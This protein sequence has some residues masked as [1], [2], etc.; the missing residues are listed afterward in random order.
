MVFRPRGQ[1]V[2]PEDAAAARMTVLCLGDSNFF[3]YP[4]DDHDAFPF[5]LQEALQEGLGKAP[6]CVINAGL[7]GYSSTQGRIWYEAEFS[8]LPYKWLLVSFL[9][10]DAWEQPRTD[11]ELLSH[12]PTR[13]Q[14]LVQD[15]ISRSRLLQAVQAMMPR[16]VSPEDYVS[17]VELSD[18][19][20]NAEFFAAQ[21]RQ[22]AH[23]IAF[24]RLP[25]V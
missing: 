7:P 12:P 23:A 10:N 18:Y 20:A 11:R 13:P 19:T 6:V 21:A 25:F 4:L 17:R 3:G 9:N 24:H 15:V 16:S 5:V 1:L 14:R 22:H 2:T 8:H